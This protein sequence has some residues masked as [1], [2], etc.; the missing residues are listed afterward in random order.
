MNYNN[1]LLLSAIVLAPVVTLL[2]CLLSGF[3][4]Q[5][6]AIPSAKTLLLVI[7]VVPLCEEIVFRGLLQNE[8]A[9]YDALRKEIL[10]ISWDN[11][12]SSSL[13]TLVHAIYFGAPILLLIQVPALIIGFFYSKHRKLIYPI[14]LH[15]WFNANGLYA[16]SLM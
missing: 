3:P 6:T 15:A 5:L 10:G 7:G 1:K 14:G 13:F 11:L 2:I 4:A 9:S 8:L 16:Y 12:I